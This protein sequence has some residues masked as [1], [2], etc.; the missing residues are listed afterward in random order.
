LKV[1]IQKLE[2]GLTEGKKLWSNVVKPADVSATLKSEVQKSEDRLKVQMEQKMYELKAK[3][4][5]E[6][7]ERVGKTKSNVKE[8]VEQRLTHHLEEEEDKKKREN[9]IM[10]YGIKESMEEEAEIKTKDAEKLGQMFDALNIQGDL[11][12]AV[13]IGKRKE[14]VSRPL[15]LTVK[16]TKKKWHIIS[17]AK[18]L[19]EQA[20]WEGVF[21]SPDLT[22]AE[23]KD[24]LAI[25]N[26]L[27]EKR[28][29]SSKKGDGRL[30][31]I[32]KRKIMERSKDPGVAC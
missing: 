12:S 1:R 30:W 16:D 18:G 19:R 5:V 11:L 4:K 2:N 14:G 26:L 27:K 31:I 22:L 9:R 24:D 8:F 3:V 28:D 15:I 7:D 25:R 21:I 29:E 17:R 23:R 32:R 20:N 6:S 13:R 10:V